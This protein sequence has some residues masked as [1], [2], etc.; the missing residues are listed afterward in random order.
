VS[1]LC[2]LC[3]FAVQFL[4]GLRVSAS[5]RE[6]CI[7]GCGFA[8]LGIGPCLSAA[9]PVFSFTIITRRSNGIENGGGMQP[10]IHL[11]WAAVL[12]SVV[13]SF[14]IGG[15]WYGPLFGKVWMKGMG[16]ESGWKPARNEMLKS[17]A[18]TILGILFMADVLAW[19]VAGWRPSTW[20]AGTDSSPAVY[21]FFA[22]FFSWLGFVVPVLLNNVAFERKKWAVFAI[23]AAHQ[24]VAMLAMGMILAY[25]R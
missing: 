22:A 15:L 17:M 14:V 13:V 1:G 4:T 21:G 18:I 6:F 23:N 24:F 19:T 25:W 16:Y 3:D 12:V 5:R 20:N 2:A 8:A 10:D 7:F 9:S 11:N